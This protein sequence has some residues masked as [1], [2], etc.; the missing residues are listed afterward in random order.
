MAAVWNALVSRKTCFPPA[1]TKPLELDDT[2]NAPGHGAGAPKGRHTRRFAVF[3][4]P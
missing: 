3:F 4:Q 2:T 1:A